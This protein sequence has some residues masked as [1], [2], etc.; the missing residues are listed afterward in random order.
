MT[1]LPTKRL[2][3]KDL[4][5]AEHRLQTARRPCAERWVILVLLC[6][7]GALLFLRNH[8]QTAHAQRIE[9]LS[10]ESV[11]LQTALELSRLQRQESQA[12]EEQLL[13]RIA[14]L[15]AQAER[16]QTDLAFFRQQKKTR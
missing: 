6:A 9:A 3:S 4:V 5:R 2:S 14:A 8:E 15:S 16:L 10:Q 7:I 13:K 12:T 11:N 1:W